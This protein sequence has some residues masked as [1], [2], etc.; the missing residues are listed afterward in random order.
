MSKQNDNQ[1]AEA[2]QGWREDGH[3]DVD[4]IREIV[5]SG[6]VTKHRA[7]DQLLALCDEV[8]RVREMH[9]KLRAFHDKNVGALIDQLDASTDLLSEVAKALTLP[10]PARTPEAEN[11]YLWALRDRALVVRESVAA[12][13]DENDAADF[14]M[15][16]RHVKSQSAWQDRGYQAR[17][18]GE[19]R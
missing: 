14:T 5:E 12:A 7:E 1:T 18:D 15:A 3:V 9:A 2:R 17:E 16:A 10:L 19:S 11:D 8:E 6:E 13:L 4:A